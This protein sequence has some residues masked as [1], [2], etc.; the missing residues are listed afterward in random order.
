MCAEIKTGGKHK[1]IEEIIGQKTCI[2]TGCIK[3]KE[4]TLIIE[5]EKIFQSWNEYIRRILQQ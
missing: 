2:S 1:R 3:S 5:K 4:G